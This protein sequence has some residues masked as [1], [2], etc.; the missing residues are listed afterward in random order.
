MNDEAIKLRPAGTTYGVIHRLGL[1]YVP[2]ARARPTFPIVATTAKVFWDEM[3]NIF[4]NYRQTAND[5]IEARRKIL[6]LVEE[7]GP[8]IWGADR[9]NVV[10]YPF[11]QYPEYTK[12]LHWDDGSG[13]RQLYDYHSQCMPVLLSQLLIVR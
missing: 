4:D 5:Q 12:D 2:P 6:S 13:T 11:P 3:F 9:L 8:Q 1:K 7:Y 10:T